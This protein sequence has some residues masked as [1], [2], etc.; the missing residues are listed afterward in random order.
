MTRGE[1][2][3]DREEDEDE[4]NGRGEVGGALERGHPESLPG[5]HKRTK[6]SRKMAVVACSALTPLYRDILR[7][8]GVDEEELETFFLYRGCSCLSYGTLLTGLC[9][10][11]DETAA[12]QEDEGSTGSFYE[13]VDAGFPA[14]DSSSSHE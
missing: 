14:G 7:G 2:L 10:A 12:S 4:R 5:I 11:W 3:G 8:K 13:G 9:S 1:G 6:S